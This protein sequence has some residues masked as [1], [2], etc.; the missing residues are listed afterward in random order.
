MNRTIRIEP[1]AVIVHQGRTK[2]N[3]REDQPITTPRFEALPTD[4]VDAFRSGA[5]DAND[6]RPEKF[7]SD[8]SG[9]P[10]RHCL[11][12]VTVGEPALV[13]AYRPFPERQPY[14]EIGPI[15]LHAEDCD[16]YD[17]AAGVPP[18][19]LA[20]KELVMRGYDEDHRIVENTGRVVPTNDVAAMA[21]TLLDRPD[22]AYIHTR[23]A[24]NTCYQCR[25]ERGPRG[26]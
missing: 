18:M 2:Q 3:R 24:W 21:A 14:A 25:I 17:P 6:M 9:I 20:R 10:C 22:V 5:P 13:L 15:F 8:G 7:I 4:I 19:I 1:A 12:D 26:S 23:C 11:S 16:R